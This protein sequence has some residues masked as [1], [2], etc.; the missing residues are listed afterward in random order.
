MPSHFIGKRSFVVV[1]LIAVLAIAGSAPGEGTIKV[2]II[3]V[4]TPHSTEFTRAMNDPQ[5]TEPLSRCKVVAAFLGGT[6]DVPA[7]VE[8][9]KQFGE[10]LR[11]RGDV[12]IVDSIDALL[13]KVDA[14]MINTLDGRPHLAEAKKVIAAGK[15]VY[16]DKPVAGS[17]AD[18]VEIYALA[19]KAGVGCFSASSLRYAKGIASIGTQ[20]D[21]AVGKVLGCSSYG[22]NTPLEPHRMPDLF[23][24]GIHG[25][26]ILF[27]IMG[28]GCETVTRVRSGSNDVVVGVWK[29]GR[30]GTYRSHPGFGA[31][32]WGDKG[33]APSGGW[34]GYDPLAVE[35]AR[36]FVTGKPPVSP[37]D[38]LE[39]YAF[40]EAADQSKR[41]GGRP[42][43][44]QSVLEKAQKEAGS[45]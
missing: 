23:Y 41:E 14:V 8:L 24:Y 34:T 29:D 6:P 18:A 4:D 45:R 16:I 1:A 20:N 31:T 2:G 28:P 36:F 12:E 7:S 5:A 3:G 42:V 43:S 38:T 35:I 25:V 15:P 21:P 17:L 10:V 26:E 39:I 37:E 40:L 33:I 32:V 27:T 11:Q 30:I 13:P 44:I 19:K 22:P 9:G